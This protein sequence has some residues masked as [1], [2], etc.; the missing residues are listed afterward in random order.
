MPR[1]YCPLSL[2]VG[3]TLDL[4]AAA[5]RHVQVLRMQPGQTLTLFG[6]CDAYGQALGGQHTAQITHM[7]RSSV[8][9]CVTG[10]EAIERELPHVTVHIACALTAN[11]RMDWL[12][13]KATELGAASFWPIAAERSV[14][15]LA[16]ERADKKRAHW[17]A[18]AVAA[19]EQSGRN[20]V[21]SVQPVAGLE[22]TLAHIAAAQLTN[23]HCRA[24]W[25][26][27]DS[28]AQPLA[29]VWTALEA[30]P[31][32]TPYEV[33]ILCGPEGGWTAAEEARA[34]AAQLTP[35]TLGTRT[36]RAETAPIAVLAALGLWGTNSDR[37]AIE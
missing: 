3:A 33:F 2:Q 24:W 15:K 12:I 4:P 31:S 11:E 23:P 26:S 19:C 37:H 10:H 32:S 29:R 9:V 34:R 18:V 7:G 22:A 14:L 21:P 13:E 17:Q 30:A 1:F 6:A 16:G 8:Q 36:L 20:R 28:D 35:M 5:V 27:L 25:L